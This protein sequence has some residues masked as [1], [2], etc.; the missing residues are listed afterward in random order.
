[1]QL[2]RQL[3]TQHFQKNQGKKPDWNANLT[4]VYL[5]N[6]DVVNKVCNVVTH[7]A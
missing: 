3:A 7:E 1:M 2:A 6:H 4:S 5:A